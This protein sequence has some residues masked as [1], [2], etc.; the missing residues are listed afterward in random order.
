MPINI[1]TINK[2][3][4]VVLKAALGIEIQFIFIEIVIF[5]TNQSMRA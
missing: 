4:M 1:K 3:F 5:I 2:R